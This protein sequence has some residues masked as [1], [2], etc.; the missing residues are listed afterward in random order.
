MAKGFYSILGAI[1]RQ[2]KEDGKIII[3]ID[4]LKNKI[5][6]SEL[7]RSE[8]EDRCKGAMAAVELYQNGFRSVIRGRGIFIDYTKARNRAVLEQLIRNVTT[9]ERQK[10]TMIDVL[11]TILD[12][13]PETADNQMRLCFDENGELAVDENGSVIL[14]E[15]MTKQEL[16]ELLYKLV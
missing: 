3:D 7:D 1:I 14:A 10:A 12:G 15:E 2:M 6:V 13:V 16:L 4:E 11:E 8:L 9:D 5:D